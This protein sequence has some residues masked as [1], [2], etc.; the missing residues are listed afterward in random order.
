VLFR[1]DLVRN[2]TDS[3]DEIETIT[4]FNA[5]ANTSLN[6]GCAGPSVHGGEMEPTKPQAW[7]GQRHGMWGHTRAVAFTVVIHRP[8]GA[9]MASVRAR[10]TDGVHQLLHGMAPVVATGGPGTAHMAA[11][12]HPQLVMA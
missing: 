3:G 7:P 4:E 6:L 1:G 9:A 12:R 11:A 10:N 5:E 2:S 8:I